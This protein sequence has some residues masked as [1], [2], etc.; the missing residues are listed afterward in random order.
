MWPVSAYKTYTVAALGRSDMNALHIRVHFAQV[1]TVCRSSNSQVEVT[2]RGHL[3]HVSIC[4]A[5]SI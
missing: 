5:H 4:T 2:I 3:Q 1:Q